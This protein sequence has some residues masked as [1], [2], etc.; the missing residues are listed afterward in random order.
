[1]KARYVVRL[2]FST[3]LIGGIVAG[4]VGYIVR[5]E[6]FQPYFS[7]FQILNILSTWFW[8]FGVGLIFSVISQMGFFAY[9]TIHRIGL[10]IFR[11]Y[12]LWN[13]VQIILIIIT[14][15]D[16]VYLRYQAFGESVTSYI[17]FAGIIFV[18][19]VI[20]AF[21]KAKLTNKGAFVPALFFMIT[22]TAIELIP[23][24]TVNERSWIDFMLYPIL[25]C[26]SYQLLILHKL[27]EWSQNNKNE[28]S[29]TK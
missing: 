5:W 26:N 23:V 19:G 24:L 13:S 22:I 4:F 27:N 3:L 6:E 1:M 29:L 9:L 28:I 7:N 11:T 21:I 8:L 10:S 18:V 12:Q 15:I 20:V 25:V 14:L 2:F 16:L 17:L